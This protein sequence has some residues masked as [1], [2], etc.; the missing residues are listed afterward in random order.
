LAQAWYA[1][2]VV[3]RKRRRGARAL[4]SAGMAPALRALALVVLGRAAAEDCAEG[5][6]RA[7]GEETAM[8]QTGRLQ[9]AQEHSHTS[10]Q[11]REK[12][13]QFCEAGEHVRCPDTGGGCAGNQ[14]CPGTFASSHHT[15]PCPSADKPEEAGCDVSVKV[16]DCLAPAPSPPAGN[17][18]MCGNCSMTG[19]T[20]PA[21]EEGLVCTPPQNILFACPV[22][23]VP[24]GNQ[25]G[26]E[27]GVS[28][29]TGMYHGECMEGLVCAPPAAGAAPGAS[30]TCANICGKFDG[31]ETEVTGA[32]N[33]MQSCTCRA[34]L[35]CSP[36]A[37]GAEGCYVYCC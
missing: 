15:Y 37:E 11:T 30:N 3:L 21:C 28:G 10:N 36:W 20:H 19:E 29:S 22:C 5:A 31:P 26:E 34:E 9:A 18:E 16:Y 12:I 1:C 27:C 32:C 23:K 33:R 35:P 13:H 7:D 14:C 25:V 8:L 17:G 4:F 24:P 2:S 6:C